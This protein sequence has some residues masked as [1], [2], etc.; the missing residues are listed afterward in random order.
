MDDLIN[1][2]A[3]FVFIALQKTELKN[4]LVDVTRIRDKLAPLIEKTYSKL[5]QQDQT[6]IL[7]FVKHQRVIYDCIIPNIIQIFKDN[8]IDLQDLPYFLNMIVGVYT[9]INEF[10]LTDKSKITISSNDI[11]E[12]TSLLIRVVL[13]LLV[14][15]EV[16]VNMINLL[17]EQ[18]VVL[19]KLK[20]GGKKCSVFPCCK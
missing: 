10:L 20:I 17:I 11:I 19:V 5:Q 7:S 8:K 1:E 14:N 3:A 15:D 2:I 4:K 12:L 16:Q 18:V 13:I 6:K 9:A